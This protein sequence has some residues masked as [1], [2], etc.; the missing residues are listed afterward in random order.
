[1]QAQRDYHEPKINEKLMTI[2]QKKTV[3]NNRI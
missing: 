3:N 2:P 1:M